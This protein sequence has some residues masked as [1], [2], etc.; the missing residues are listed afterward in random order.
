MGLFDGLDEKL[1]RRE[2]GEEERERQAAYN[3]TREQELATYNSVIMRVLDA[4]GG[5]LW[6]AEGHRVQGP[7]PRDLIE[8]TP[9]GGDDWRLNDYRGDVEGLVR[10]PFDG[11]A[12]W[13]VRPLK[14]SKRFPLGIV[15]VTTFDRSPKVS[16]ILVGEIEDCG[17]PTTSTQLN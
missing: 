14:R 12:R 16:G 6:A 7:S 15:V 13:I 8:R 10:P 1:K 5:Q 11:A 3:L 4:L 2:S 9:A 17:R